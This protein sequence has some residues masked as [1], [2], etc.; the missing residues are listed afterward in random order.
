MGE[1]KSMLSTKIMQEMVT[2]HSG[3]LEKNFDLAKQFVSITKEGSVDVLVKQKINGADQILLY[4]I[5]K[6][7][8]KEAGLTD[9]EDVGSEELMTELGIPEGSVFPWLKKLSDQRKI[10]KIRRGNKVNHKIMTNVIE[11]TLK[12]IKKKVVK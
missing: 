5:G 12:T 6:L 1:D 11:T 8:A 4:L 10:K 3:A 7:Y 9:L 2:D